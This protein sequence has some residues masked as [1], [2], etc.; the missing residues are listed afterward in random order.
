VDLL[1]EEKKIL[2]VDDESSVRFLLSEELTQQG[3]E[4]STAASGEEALAMLEKAAFD[5]M[6]LDLKMPGMDGIEVMRV[7]RDLAPQTVV[8]MLTAY[9]T[10]DSAVEALRYGGHDYLLKPSSPD[11][12]RASVERGLAKRQ[13]YR[14]QEDL[15]RQMGNLARQL[16]EGEVT[17][18]ET[19]GRGDGQVRYLRVGDLLL[20]RARLNVI[21][22]G[23]SVPLTPSEYRLLRILMENAGSTVSFGALAEAVHGVTC[24]ERTAKKAISTHLWRLRRKLDTVARSPVKIVNIRG[25]GY[26]LLQSQAE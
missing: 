19:E 20:D 23:E 16:A 2:V 24:E 8:V 18:T 5:L 12:I 17:S 1:A 3:Y 6:L 4:V 14:R 13:Q 21:S 22:A 10:L 26:V 25:E 7:A 11:E 9:A 15:I